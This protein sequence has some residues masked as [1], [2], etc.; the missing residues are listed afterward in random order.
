MHPNLAPYPEIAAT[1]ATLQ[2]EAQ[3]I[4]SRQFTALYLSG[5][6]AL[7]DFNPLTSDIDFFV[8]TTDEPLADGV[9]HELALLHQ[10]LAQEPSG[11]GYELEGAY[12]PQRVLRHFEAVD[13]ARYPAFERGGKLKFEQLGG[14]WLIHC[15]TLYHHGLALAGPPPQRFLQPVAPD[16][17]RHA[18]IDLLGWWDQQLEDSSLLQQPAYQAYA[19]LTMCRIFYTMAHGDIVSKPVAARWARQQLGAPWRELIESGLRWAP[20]ADLPPLS[21]TLDFISYTLSEVR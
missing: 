11:W 8:I 6:L 9:L 19:I 13:D 1:L 3:R 15:H 5:S 17:L 7:G 14:P 21:Q 12:L 20:G 4:L 10:R 16:D 2:Q 18:V